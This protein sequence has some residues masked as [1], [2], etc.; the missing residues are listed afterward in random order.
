MIRYFEKG[1]KQSIKA[2]MNQDDSQLIDYEEL[3]AKVMRAEA[4]AGLRPSSYMQ[5]TDLSYFRGNRLAHITAHKFQT[6]GAGKNH[7]GDDSKT[8]KGSASTLASASIQDSELAIKPRKI[9]RRRTSEAR[10]ILG[11]P[12]ISLPRLLESTRPR[13][14]GV[15]R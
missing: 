5:E 13:L 10:E 7:C 15:D 9:R 11:N 8:S 14:V 2:E 4:K 3:I 6:K 12:K 1:L